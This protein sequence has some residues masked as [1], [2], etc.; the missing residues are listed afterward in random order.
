MG[1]RKNLLFSFSSGYFQLGL[2]F[3]A[4]LFIARLLAP[5]EFG[6]FSIAM[7][8]IFLAD[9]LRNFGIVS[10]VIQEK[11]LTPA[12]LNT[13]SGLNVLTSYTMA[14]AVVLLAGPAARFYGEEG[15]RDVMW[16]LA[17]NFL[18]LPIGATTTAYMRRE[19]MFKKVAAI[20]MANAATSS[21]SAVF[22]A[23]AGYSYMSL[24]M[25]NVL[26]TVVTVVLT[27]RLKPAGLKIRPSL[28]EV[29]RVLGFGTLS[30]VTSLAGETSMRLPSLILGRV[31]DLESAGLFERASSVIGLFR[32]LVV[33]GLAQ[34]TLPHI[35]A[36]ARK[37]E[38]VVASVLLTITH[39]TVVGWPFFLIIALVAPWLIPILY[40]DQWHD[41]VPLAQALCVG[42][43]FMV[44]FYLQWQVLVAKGRMS[45]QTWLT[46]FGVLVRAPTLVVLAPLGLKIAVLGYAV[47]SVFVAMVYLMVTI[48]VVGCRPGQLWRA[49]VPS[50]L[51]SFCV[52]LVAALTEWRMPMGH[53]PNLVKLVVTPCVAVAV[54]P[55]GLRLAGHPMLTELRNAMDFLASKLRSF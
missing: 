17:V 23:Y 47:A 49:L 43:L 20:Q 33:N 24:A 8:V 48:R 2:Q 52:V 1:I 50:L 37:N 39:L 3:V 40:G 36:Q 7:G 10:Y 44:P 16:L 55:L 35:A 51:V 12:R 31:I 34:V 42:E 19:L 22:L 5:G 27:W 41:S 54:W 14:A 15:V 25:G 29:R 32:R 6:I 11:D 18:L 13:A 28:T 30:T 46:L 4:S 21:I 45:T 38:N 26:A 9:T 53:V